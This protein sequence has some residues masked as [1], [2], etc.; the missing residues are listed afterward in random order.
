MKPPRVQS[1]L[2]ALILLASSSWSSG[3][4]VGKKDSPKPTLPTWAK[5]EPSSDWLTVAY[6]D[7]ATK[8]GTVLYCRRSDCLSNRKDGLAPLYRLEA[9]KTE[10]IPVNMKSPRFKTIFGRTFSWTTTKKGTMERI[11]YDSELSKYRYDLAS[12]ELTQGKFR[13]KFEIYDPLAKHDSHS[14]AAMPRIMIVSAPKNGAGD[15]VASKPQTKPERKPGTKPGQKPEAKPEQKPEQQSEAKP[16]AKPEQRPETVLDLKELDES[17]LENLSEAE[18]ISYK[19]RLAQAKGQKDPAGIAAVIAEYRKKAADNAMNAIPRN[20]DELNAKTKPQQNKFCKDLLSVPEGG[21]VGGFQVVAGAKEQLKT[22][23]TDT[24]KATAVM[25]GE[26]KKEYAA[27]S[28]APPPQIA[29]TEADKIR[30]RCKELMAALPASSGRS[31]G[32][33]A[34]NVPAVPTAGTDCEKKDGKCVE[35]KKAD[36]NEWLAVKTGAVGMLPGVMFGSFFGPVGIVIGAAVGFGLFWGLSK[37]T[38]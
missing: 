25:G 18:K 4:G 24:D 14:F 23:A 34:G 5:E 29:K 32:N 11:S 28:A 30:A 21:Y 20:V 8:K 35:P 12:H 1:L 2:A 7:P 19:E 27:V 10:T 16:E 3:A 13:Q 15:I 6:T 17:E 36:P 9:T 26:V 38:N 22:A 33:I 31:Q 37:L